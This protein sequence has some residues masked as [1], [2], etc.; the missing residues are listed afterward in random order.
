MYRIG[1]GEGHR[2]TQRKR[3]TEDT[4]KENTFFLRVLCVSPCNSV[5]MFALLGPAIGWAQ[6]D[7][8]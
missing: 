2:V 1:G 3:N 6:Q 5:T 7:G 4:E 8:S